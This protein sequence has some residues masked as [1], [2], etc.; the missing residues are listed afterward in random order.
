MFMHIET[1]DNIAIILH[2][3]GLYDIYWSFYNAKGKAVLCEAYDF[4]I[5]DNFS[6]GILDNYKK[7]AKEIEDY[8]NQGP[9]IDGVYSVSLPEPCEDKSLIMLLL[10]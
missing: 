10:V 2:N 8:L 4:D 5:E 7:A 6:W 1:L 9:A 3:N